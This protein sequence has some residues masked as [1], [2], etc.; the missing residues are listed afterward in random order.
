MFR[1]HRNMRDLALPPPVTEMS[2]WAATIAIV[3]ALAAG[4]YGTR[5]WMAEKDEIGQR[6]TMADAV[7]AMWRARRGDAGG[8]DGCDVGTVL[9][10]LWKGGGAPPA[11]L[12]RSA[13]SSQ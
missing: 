12:T 1:H 11:L 7:K 3:V 9:P 2:T 4:I 8:V 10:V 6:A 13:F 5:W